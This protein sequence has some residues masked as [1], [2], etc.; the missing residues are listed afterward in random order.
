MGILIRHYLHADPAQDLDELME[1]YAEALFIEERQTQVM[2]AAI[3]KA[4]GGKQ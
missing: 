4:F 3:S 2:A 1:Q